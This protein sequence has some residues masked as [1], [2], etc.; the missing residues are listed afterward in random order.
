MKN[1]KMV[2]SVDVAL[3]KLGPGMV[4]IWDGKNFTWKNVFIDPIKRLKLDRKIKLNKLN[5]NAS[6]R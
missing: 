5:D 3:S 1:Q 2:M 6:I 4:V